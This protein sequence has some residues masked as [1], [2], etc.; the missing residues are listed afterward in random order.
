MSFEFS[1]HDREMDLYDFNPGTGEFTR[2]VLTLIKANEGLPAYT[3][4]TPIPDLPEG[5][6][7]VFDTVLKEWE[8]VEDNRGEIAYSKDGDSSKDY[9]VA[10]LD[11][12]PDTH[13]LVVKPA[14]PDYSFSNGAWSLNPDLVA[15][16][17]A[18]CKKEKC[19]ELRQLC[20]DGICTGF[21]SDALGEDLSY[22]CRQDDQEKMWVASESA[23]GGKI[24][25]GELYTHH[26]QAQGT[27]VYALGLALI[28]SCTTVYADKL[29]E[30]AAATTVAEVE[31]I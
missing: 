10:T 24:W 27:T 30:V 25:A 17:L 4:N 6:V 20:G 19:A 12:I 31:A 7:A 11:P 28:E 5:Y 22:R 15:A 21:N 1:D 16:T 3:T 2:E 14:G 18:E 29:L 26:T 23:A 8:T 13:T 9:V